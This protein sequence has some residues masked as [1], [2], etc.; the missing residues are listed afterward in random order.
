LG[1]VPIP[2]TNS[3]DWLE[4][5]IRSDQRKMVVLIRCKTRKDGTSETQAT[6]VCREQQ[7]EEQRAEREK[8]KEKS[9]KRQ[10]AEK[11]TQ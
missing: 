8:T 5:K 9:V 1:I 2:G 4:H 6:S 3:C 10:K 11:S 7:A